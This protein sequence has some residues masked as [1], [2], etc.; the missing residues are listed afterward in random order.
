MDMKKPQPAKRVIVDVPIAP[1]TSLLS[2]AGRAAA[3]IALALAKRVETQS[4]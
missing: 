2:P 3:R 4:S 1:S